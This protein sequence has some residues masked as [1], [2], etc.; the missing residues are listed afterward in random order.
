MPDPQRT[1]ARMVDVH[2]AGRGIDDPKIL[3]AFR[4]VPRESFLPENLAEF[5][6]VDTPLPIIVSPPKRFG[7]ASDLPK[8]V[9]ETAEPIDDIETA[10]LDAL[11]DRIGDARLVLLGEATHGTSEFYRMRARASRASS[12][13]G[14]ASSSSPWRLTLTRIESD[15][16]SRSVIESLRNARG[17]NRATSRPT[18]R[19]HPRSGGAP[20]ARSNRPS[21]LPPASRG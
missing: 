4:S 18:S 10:R 16:R 7:G 21:T 12:S 20:A 1:R 3:D 11:L 5:A 17:A 13:L 6:Y 15:R 14:A 8:L 2:I 9:R 19:E